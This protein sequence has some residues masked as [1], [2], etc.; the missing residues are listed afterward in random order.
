[1]SQ[2]PYLNEVTFTECFNKYYKPC[3]FFIYNYVKDLQM[4][5][6][7]AKEAFMRMW[8][9]KENPACE[10]EAK[11]FIYIS[12]K[13]LALNAIRHFKV[14]ENR[15]KEITKYMYGEPEDEEVALN[16][17]IRSEFL[18]LVYAAIEKLAPEQR[19]VIKAC[20]INGLDIPSAMKY[21]SKNFRT[22]KEQK[23]KGLQN[24]RLILNNEETIKNYYL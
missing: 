10:K 21:L 19:K 3:S 1:M 4:A 14:V 5:E 12:A 20:F 6:D 11:A 17:M 16:Q 15:S 18:S 9:K 23:R 13:N 8:D 2:E 22:L 24:L 7:I